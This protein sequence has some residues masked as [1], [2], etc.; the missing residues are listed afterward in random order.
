MI[1]WPPNEYCNHCFEKVNWKKSEG[2]GNIVEY[3]KKDETFFCLAEFENKIR[4]M[5]KL[6]VNSEN[7]KVGKKVKLDS[8]D[9]TQMHDQA[10]AELWNR[11]ALMF[12]D[13]R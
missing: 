11:F 1:I 10:H 12:L 6:I 4:I 2:V 7:P 5:G 13:R 8:C 3:S 9:P